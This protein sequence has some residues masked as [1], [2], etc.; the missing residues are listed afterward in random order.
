[1]VRIVLLEMTECTPIWHSGTSGTR[2]HCGNCEPY[3]TETYMRN[4]LFVYLASF[5]CLL[6]IQI[7]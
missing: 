6:I 4:R 7:H 1:M 3:M 2:C 5:I